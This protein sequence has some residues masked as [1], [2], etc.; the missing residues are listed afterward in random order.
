MSVA[1]V[2]AN[3]TLAARAHDWDLVLHL[4]ASHHGW[5]RPL[6]PPIRDREPVNVHATFDG[7]SLSKDSD[8]ALARIDSGVTER[9]WRLVRRYGWWGLAWL[10]A[11]VRLADHRES[12]KEPR[13][14]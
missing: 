10:E 3:P 8:H 9:F 2:E 5:C 4:V 1:L 12:E 13:D 6:A 14:G 11:I 7:I